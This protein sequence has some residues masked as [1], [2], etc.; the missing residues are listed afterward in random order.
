ML[1]MDELSREL[2]KIVSDINART[3]HRLEGW[4]LSLIHI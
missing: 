1:T 2:T 4:E 3:D